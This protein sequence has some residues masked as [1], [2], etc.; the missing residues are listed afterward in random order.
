[1]GCLS[2]ATR[3]WRAVEVLGLGVVVLPACS[4]RNGVEDGGGGLQDEGEERAGFGRAISE[5]N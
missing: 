3:P 1:M 2:T 4:R 5:S